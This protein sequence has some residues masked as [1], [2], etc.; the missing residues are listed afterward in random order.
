MLPLLR[1]YGDGEPHWITDFTDKLAAEF[2]LSESDADARLKSGGTI[3][4]NRVGW[5]RSDLGKAKL[6]ERVG[7]GTWRITDRGRALLAEPPDRLTRKYLSARYLEH[8]EF[9]AVGKQVR[10]GPGI[11]TATGAQSDESP[12]ESTIPPKERM[13]EAYQELTASL[14]TELRDA[15]KSVSPARFEELVLQVLVAMG[16][17]GALPD[18][19]LR[20]GGAGDGGI[21]GEIRED[22]LGLDT[23]YVQAKRWDSSVGR[24][25]VQGFVGSLVGRRARK[26]VVITT[27]AFTADAREYVNS[28]DPRVVLIDGVE[29][30][31]LMIEYNVGVAV[32]TMFELKR[33]DSDF[34]DD[35]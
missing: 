4:L 16:Y 14:A 23:I 3:W 26:G 24:P 1:L 12:A 6:L 34:F 9:L 30:A 18:S 17:G 22:K 25:V 27:S 31:R 5:A 28:I 8:A 21:D 29:L 2:S 10:P 11:D 32:E 33:V 35:V 7:R 13:D 19:A 15:L 20:S